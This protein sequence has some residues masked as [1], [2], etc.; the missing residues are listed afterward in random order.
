MTG[1]ALRAVI[2]DDEALARRGIHQLLAQHADVDVVSEC[3]NGR[4]ALT[5]LEREMVDLVYLDI[6]MPELNG[7][8]VVRSLI[9][10]RG[11]DAVPAIVFLTAYE[12]FAV[13]AFEVEAV[14]YLVKPV[15]Q[16]RFDAALDRV[17][18]RLATAEHSPAAQHLVVHTA[19][20]K[21]LVP[22]DEI[23]WIG[24]DDYY[25]AIHTAA[26]RYLLRETMASLEE[27]LD[28]HR[29]VR[30]HRGAIVHLAAVREF[31]RT[32]GETM[33]ILVDGTQL[34]VSRRRRA[35]LGRFFA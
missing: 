6:Q 15:S 18:R 7:F 25:A 30:V 14:D 11:A 1:T 24:A 5:L 31:R 21:Q 12:D 35:A 13:E 19:R 28:R 34:P 3:R 29:F 16:Q 2:V 33:L 20:G 22:I 27:R 26:R 10:N 32:D 8:E 17:R 9:A 23:L 4:E